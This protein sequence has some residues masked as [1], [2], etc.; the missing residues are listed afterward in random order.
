MTL[1][2]RSL[3]W[4]RLLRQILGHPLSPCSTLHWPENGKLT[5][6]N[7]PLLTSDIGKKTVSILAHNFFLPQKPYS[8]YILSISPLRCSRSKSCVEA[9]INVLR[10]VL[11]TWYNGFI[12]LL[13]SRVHQEV[14]G[15]IYLEC[16]MT[17]TVFFLISEVSKFL[18]S[19]DHFDKGPL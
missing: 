12:P 1:W 5:R 11:S 15:S 16:A 19:I 9:Q 14:Y 17:D 13:T 6:E 18:V 10:H 3:W 8:G 4:P 2:E 7:E